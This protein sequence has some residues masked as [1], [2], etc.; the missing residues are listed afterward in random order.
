MQKTLKRLIKKEKVP[1]EE[2]RNED[3]LW[4]NNRDNGS[5]E[6]W[7]NLMRLNCM[8]GTSW[9][10]LM[11]SMPTRVLGVENYGTRV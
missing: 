9:I 7:I 10:V 2:A 11:P 6:S 8:M 4:E 5:E 3:L 1:K